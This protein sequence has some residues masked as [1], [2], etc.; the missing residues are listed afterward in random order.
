MFKK[1]AELLTDDGKKKPSKKAAKK[2]TAKPTIHHQKASTPHAS[3]DPASLI[4]QA[5]LEAEQTI[6]M[7]EKIAGHDPNHLKAVQDAMMIYRQKQENLDHLPLE[8]KARLRALGEVMFGSQLS[9][10]NKNTKKPH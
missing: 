1:L 9:D 3:D 8:E 7:E 5:I 4:K 2:P 10:A 6:A